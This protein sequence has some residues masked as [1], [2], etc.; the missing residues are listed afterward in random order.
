MSRQGWTK[1]T[2]KSV[3]FFFLIFIFF[4]LSWWIGQVDKIVQLPPQLGAVHS[5]FDSQSLTVSFFLSCFQHPISFIEF[6]LNQRVVLCVCVAYTCCH[7]YMY[8]YVCIV[9]M[10]CVYV[11]SMCCVYVLCMCIVYMCCVYFLCI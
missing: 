11:L 7:V 5:R 9:Y 10:C 2:L 8:Y 6:P 3:L 4:I 1:P